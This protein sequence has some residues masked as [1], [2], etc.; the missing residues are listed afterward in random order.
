MR[1]I[2]LIPEYSIQ[3]VTNKQQQVKVRTFIFFC[4]ELSGIIF[5]VYRGFL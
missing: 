3:D 4:Y 5:R 2:K 1:L